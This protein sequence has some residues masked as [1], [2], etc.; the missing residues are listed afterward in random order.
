MFLG[1]VDY[2]LLYCNT[3]RCNS[4]TGRA[5]IICSASLKTARRLIALG[6]HTEKEVCQHLHS[7]DPV[8]VHTVRSNVMPFAI[9]EYVE[10]NVLNCIVLRRIAIIIATH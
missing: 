7:N 3:Y 5:S 9:Y 1:L 10:V 6:F 8:R 2:I 4:V